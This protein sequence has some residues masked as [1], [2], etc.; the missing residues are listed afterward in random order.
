MCTCVSS[1]F[2]CTVVQLNLE[3]WREVHWQF[4]ICKLSWSSGWSPILDEQWFYLHVCWITII[5]IIELT[6]NTCLQCYVNEVIRFRTRKRI[7][8]F[9]W[10]KMPASKLK[11]LK[12][13]SSWIWVTW[14]HWVMSDSIS[15]SRTFLVILNDLEIWKRK[16]QLGR[17][18]FCRYSLWFAHHVLQTN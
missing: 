7:L 13:F 16:I 9:D 12:L 14:F 4:L 6:L 1:F 2:F 8:E 15:N 5:C 18:R 10:N 11:L 17:S 3:R